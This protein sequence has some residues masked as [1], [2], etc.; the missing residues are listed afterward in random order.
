MMDSLRFNSIIAELDRR[1]HNSAHPL[2]KRMLET[3]TW[4]FKNEPHLPRDDLRRRLDFVTKYCECMVENF[5]WMV[6]R[7]QEEKGSKLWLPTGMNS[8]GD[9]TKFG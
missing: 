7:L 3:T 2:E 9:M 6:E 1:A 8:G 5:A 4:F